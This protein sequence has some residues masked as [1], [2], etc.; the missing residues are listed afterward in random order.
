MRLWLQHHFNALHIMCR[1]IEAGVPKKAAR[2][3]SKWY[4]KIVHPLLY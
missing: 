2:K 4:E 3:L 1:M